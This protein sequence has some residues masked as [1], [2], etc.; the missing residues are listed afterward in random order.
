MSLYDREYMRQRQS[1]PQWSGRQA[2]LVLILVNVAFFLLVP[3]V[4][5]LFG[6]LALTINGAW[7]PAMIWQIFTAGFL[8]ANFT[9]IL[10]NM[11]GLY[12]FG[13][14]VAPHMSGWKFV[15]LYLA[16]AATGNLLFLLC[17][18][19]GFS[20]VV[21]ASGAVFAVMAAAATLEPDRKFVMI[22]VPFFPLKTTTLVICYT[23]LEI[24]F[25]RSSD[26]IAHLAH[27]GGFLGG[28]LVMLAYFGRS[29]PWDPFRKLFNLSARPR[30]VPP[31][32]ASG[33]GTRV[34]QA[35]LDALL[36]KLSTQGINSLSEYELE[37]LR[38]ARRQMRGEE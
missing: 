8:H 13:K 5:S 16:G 22:F 12:I 25:V 21:G 31:P 14:L 36:D 24:L 4:S 32:S 9:H 34:T 29:L 3:R 6:A 2:L 17:N 1:R 23:I 28:Y 27:L 15:I 33:S 38:K 18:L 37:R 7:D 35:E 26:G 10:F 30:V 11:W 20:Q 19:N